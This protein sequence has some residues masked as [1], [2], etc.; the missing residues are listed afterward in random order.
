MSLNHQRFFE[1]TRPI[2][3][4]AGVTVIA[5]LVGYWFARSKRSALGSHRQT[6]A[7][8]FSGSGE[9]ERGQPSPYSQGGYDLVDEASWESFPAS[10]PP[11]W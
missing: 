11:G 4:A 3:F 10:D 5:G 2:A 9:S 7:G 6:G 1:E 8:V